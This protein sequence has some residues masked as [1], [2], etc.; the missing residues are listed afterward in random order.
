MYEKWEVLDR[1]RECPLVAEELGTVGVLRLWSPGALGRL[2]VLGKAAGGLIPSSLLAP[3][4]D[5]EGSDKAAGD[6]GTAGGR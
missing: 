2:K 5:C 6:E 4:P 1:V 3:S